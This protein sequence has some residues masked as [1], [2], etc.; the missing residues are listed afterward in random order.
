MATGQAGPR[1]ATSDPSTVAPKLRIDPIRGGLMAK[2]KARRAAQKNV[3]SKA[4]PKRPSVVI[5]ASV[6]RNLATE[7]EAYAKASQTTKSAV[8]AGALEA[9]LKRRRKRR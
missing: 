4:A 1:W 2:S 7:L 8:I 6:S 9:F 3:R 5:A